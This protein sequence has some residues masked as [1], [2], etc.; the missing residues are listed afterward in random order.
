MKKTILL[1]GA[2]GS[3]GSE[4]LRELIRQQNRYHIRIFSL[5]T[6]QERKIVQPFSAQVEVVWGDLRNPTEVLRAVRG[7]DVVLH[8]AAIIPPLA[9]HHPQLVYDVNVGGTSNILAAMRAQKQPPRLIFTSSISVYGDRVDDPFIRVGDPISPSVGDEYARTKIRAEEM[10]QASGMAWSIFRLCGIL[11]PTL[12]IQPLMF[13]MPLETALE[14]CHNSDAGLALVN[15]IENKA[16]NGKIFNLG[17]GDTCQIKARDFIHTT[18]P[19]YGLN[20]KILPEYAF[21]TQNFHSGYYTDSQIL[22]DLLRFQRKSLSEYFSDARKSIS[23]LRKTLFKMIPHGIVRKYLEGLSE[24]LRAIRE[25]NQK[26]IARFYGSRE[27]F[28]R[29]L[30][31]KFKKDSGVIG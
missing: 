11:T 10:V 28:E 12:K 7:V 3:V 23:P 9:D 6:P 17:G 2:T 13:H 26:M 22:N 18:L 14:W 1:T 16:I 27:A 8:V 20:P 25:N 15:A 19:L 31:Q 29:L 5:D 30:P 4:A 24:P 21:A